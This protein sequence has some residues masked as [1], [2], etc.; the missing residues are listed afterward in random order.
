MKSDS[1]LY[2]FGKILPNAV[3]FKDPKS[4]KYLF[5][6]ELS[7]ANVGAGSPEQMLGLTVRD[8]NFSQKQSQ[9]GDALAQKIIRMDWF[10]RDKKTAI[11]DTA[12]FLKPDGVLIVETLT[13]LPILGAHGNVTGIATFNQELTHRVSHRLLYDLYKNICGTKVAAKKFLRHLDIESWFYTLPTEAELLVL[14]ERAGGNADK[15]IAR[16]QGVSTRTI[17]THFVNLRSKLKGDALPNI[18]SCL[19]NPS[20]TI[21]AI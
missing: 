1:Q 17:E 15:E 4:G 14:I 3:N 18:I 8:L 10:V 13:K 6:N 7:A 2:D 19:R 5:S 21:S 16:I 20:H 11:D 9:W 12:A